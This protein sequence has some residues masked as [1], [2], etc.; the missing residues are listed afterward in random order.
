QKLWTKGL[1][2]LLKNPPNAVLSVF[3]PGKTDPS[4]TVVELLDMRFDGADLVYS[5]RVLKDTPHAAGGRARSL[6]T[7]CRCRVL[8]SSRRATVTG[9]DAAISDHRGD[10]DGKKALLR[11]KRLMV[12][13]RSFMTGP[14]K[15][16][17]TSLRRRA[18]AWVGAIAFAYAI[19]G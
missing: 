15:R 12:M 10:W 6:S 5:I 9:M 13:G 14:D 16:P 2:S 4:E 1:D 7:A 19:L 17:V 8:L 3:E 11:G 18:I